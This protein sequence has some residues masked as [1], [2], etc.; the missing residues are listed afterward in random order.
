ML[1]Y[2][3]TYEYYL[4]IPEL[5]FY[6]GVCFNETKILFNHIQLPKFALSG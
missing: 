4:N 2:I 6:G 5:P 1:K 3:V